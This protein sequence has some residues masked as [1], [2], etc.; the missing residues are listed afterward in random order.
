MF[1]IEYY[2]TNTENKIILGERNSND[3]DDKYLKIMYCLIALI[4]D[5]TRRK[6]T[7]SSM[8]SFYNKNPNTLNTKK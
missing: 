3:D 5:E 4:L 8:F 7:R 1:S 6:G 2:G